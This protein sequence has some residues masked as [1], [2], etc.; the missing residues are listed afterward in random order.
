MGKRAAFRLEPVL[1]VRAA[2]EE[3]ASRAAA[4]AEA[5]ARDAAARAEE[6]A[7]ALAGRVPPASSPAHV[8]LAAMVASAAAAADVAAARSTAQ[9]SAEQADLLRQR[10][11]AAAQETRALERLRERH[12][13][14]LRAAELTAEERAVD[15]LVTR[16]HAVRAA[17]DDGEEEPWRA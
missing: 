15:D 16:R 3:A 13:L 10:W 1:R 5:A 9:A 17:T 14:A 11:T 8:F 6:L 4:E 12:L 2:A 7:A